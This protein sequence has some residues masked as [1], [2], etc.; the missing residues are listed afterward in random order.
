MT[1]ETGPERSPTQSSLPGAAAFLGMGIS[2]AA[3]VG[4]GVWLG[5][6]ADSRLHTAPALLIVGVVLGVVVSV[7]S[8]VAQIKRFL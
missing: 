1:D 8:V 6:L 3:S 4:A 7:V 5:L 2:I